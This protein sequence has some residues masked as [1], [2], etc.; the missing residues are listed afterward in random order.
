MK[1]INKLLL[2]V[3]SLGFIGLFGSPE[4][5]A[6]N[7]HKQ[8]AS[9][10]SAFRKEQSEKV[11]AIANKINAEKNVSGD[12]QTSVRKAL[13]ETPGVTLENIASA[14]S[15][16]HLESG[17]LKEVS[18]AISEELSVER[19]TVDV[20]LVTE[21]YMNEGEV[22]ATRVSRDLNI[23]TEVMA[24]TDDL[25]A[26]SSTDDLTDGLQEVPMWDTSTS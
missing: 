12:L 17:D 3:S 19:S 18:K 21:S 4:S 22:L 7:T 13:R 23:P 16:M 15:Q 2:S 20:S 14:V 24:P 10:G 11:E 5:L 1:Y 6:S 25:V 8:S 9:S 26:S